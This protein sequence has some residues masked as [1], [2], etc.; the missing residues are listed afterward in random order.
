MVFGVEEPQ[1]TKI[2]FAPL[3]KL[4]FPSKTVIA[5]FPA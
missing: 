2:Q 4:F 3:L 5:A 1:V